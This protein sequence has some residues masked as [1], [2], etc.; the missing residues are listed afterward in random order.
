M[1]HTLTLLFTT[2]FPLARLEVLLLGG[3]F[4]EKIANQVFL[5]KF[6]ASV[7]AKD[8]RYST[9]KLTDDIGNVSI[10]AYKEWKKRDNSSLMSIAL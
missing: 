6:P 7:N 9:P 10:R 1:N 5:A 8:L 3:T 2:N 4:E